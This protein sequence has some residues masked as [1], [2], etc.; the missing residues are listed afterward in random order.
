MPL[1]PADIESLALAY[2][3]AWCSRSGE[4]V[5]AFFS[6][7]A[8][9][10]INGG[11]PTIGR[12]AIAD[13]MGAFFVEFPDLVLK[14]DALRSGGNQAIYLWTLEGTNSETGN[15]VRIPGWQNWQVSDAGLIANADGGFDAEEYARQVESG[16]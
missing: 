10:I 3:A 9:S 16:I 12:A 2:T 4:A 11:E 6:E 8:A 5:A 7:D 14:M 1:S 13:A 15:F